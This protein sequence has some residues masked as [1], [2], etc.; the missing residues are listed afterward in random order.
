[1]NDIIFSRL[2]EARKFESDIADPIDRAFVQWAIN[3]AT[4]RPVVLSDT[5]YGPFDMLYFANLMLEISKKKN[6]AKMIFE[7]RADELW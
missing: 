6:I 3:R 4:L 5:P 2:E 7:G 1:M